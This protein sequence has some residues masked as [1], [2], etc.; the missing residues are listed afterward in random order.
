MLA[1]NL[2]AHTDEAELFTVSVADA[3][4]HAALEGHLDDYVER[5]ALN[6]LEHFADP[7]TDEA[8]RKRR[9]TDGSVAMIRQVHG[10][11]RLI[12]APGRAAL[13]CFRP[14]RSQHEARKAA[15]NHSR[16][17]GCMT[18]TSLALQQ[19]RSD[20]GQEDR[21]KNETQAAPGTASGLDQAASAS[22]RSR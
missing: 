3:G 5:P 15:L 9:A 22:T 19:Q 7:A 21:E 8:A 4:V 6:S 16:S 10:Q 14:R 11:G 18:S 1:C 17:I 2:I 12:C 13:Y 20:Q